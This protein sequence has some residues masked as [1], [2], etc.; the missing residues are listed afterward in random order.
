MK[1]QPRS[2][3]QPLGVWARRVIRARM[4]RLE[5]ELGRL[6]R[7]P[8]AD[9][10][11]DVRV[12]N[13]RVRAALRHLEPCFRA[14]RAERLG[15]VLRRVARLLGGIRDLDILMENLAADAARPGSPLAALFKGLKVRRD[16][17]LARALPEA[18]LLRLRLP[19]WRE[20]L[21]V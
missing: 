14:G 7:S 1:V 20:R 18:R 5:R 12:A 3:R 16:E 21:D 10:I 19:A 6:E 15:L 8:H 2:Q 11:H 13:R 9:A 4:R 17:K